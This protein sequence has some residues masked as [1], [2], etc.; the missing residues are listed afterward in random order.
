MAANPSMALELG[1][2]QTMMVMFFKHHPAD[3]CIQYDKLFRQAAAQDRSLRWDAVK[4]DIYVWAVTQPS[5]R[6]P[7]VP[8]HTQ[9]FREKVP[10]VARLGPPAATPTSS[11]P[12]RLSIHHT[13]YTI[14]HTPG[15]QEICRRYNYGK[16]T[17]GSE[18]SFAHVC[19]GTRGALG[20][21]CKRVPQEIQLSPSGLIC[22]YDTF[23]RRELNTHPDRAWVSWLLHG[24]KYRVQKDTTALAA[25]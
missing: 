4:N 11:N 19:A 15:G 2:Y 17:R 13:P 21:P 3:A 18:Y 20:P 22:H 7:G 5:F 14:H 8:Q 6:Q 10:V 16:C 12:T 1:K 24:M 9:S 25:R 23:I